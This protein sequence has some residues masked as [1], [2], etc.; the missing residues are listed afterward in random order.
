MELK[1]TQPLVDIEFNGVIHPVGLD[2]DLNSLASEIQIKDDNLRNNTEILKVE[3]LKKKSP[4]GWVDSESVKIGFS[5]RDLPK[6]IV[7][8]K[9]SIYRVRPYENFPRQCFK[10]QRMAVAYLLIISFSI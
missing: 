9:Y 5:G 8:S 10:C 6:T 2:T 1:C 7:I 3:R 4:Q